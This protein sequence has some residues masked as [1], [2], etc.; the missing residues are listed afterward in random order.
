M[1]YLDDKDFAHFRV[2]PRFTRHDHLLWTSHSTFRGVRVSRSLELTK[3]PICH[4]Q[5]ECAASG[6]EDLPS[7][8]RKCFSHVKPPSEGSNFE[9]PNLGGYAF[10]SLVFP[11]QELK[12]GLRHCTLIGQTLHSKLHPS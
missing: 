4:S 9:A 2:D 10:Y 5:K 7:M 11:R 6:L 12:V 3:S 1:R 8:A